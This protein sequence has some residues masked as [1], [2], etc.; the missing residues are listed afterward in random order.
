MAPKLSHHLIS[1]AFFL[2]PLL[3]QVSV[4]KSE[5]QFSKSLHF[6][7]GAQIGHA[8]KGLNQ[9]K[10]YFNA[11]GYYPSGINLTDDFDDL[12]ESALKIYQKQYRLEV[13]GK[14]D[15]DTIENML[16]PRCGV[17]DVF[18]K[19]NDLVEFDMV[20]NYTF[21]N[22]M[23]RWN[24]RQLTY[25]FRSSAQ[26]IS[27]QQLRPIIARAFQRWAAV[28]GFTFQE[29]PLFTQA[30][31][32]IGFHR[33]FHWDGY[34]FDGPGNVLAH[35]F[36]PQDGRLHY[37]ADENWSTTN[38]TTINQ[39]DLESVAVHEIGHILGL[40]HSQDPRAIMFA[41]YMPG[42]IKRNLGQDDI[43]GIRALYLG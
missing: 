25:T 23:P 24:T 3:V 20:A 17:Q 5:S 16:I 41:Y 32:V 10:Q 43:D 27:V 19:P 31:I 8:F 1:Y 18:N 26:V 39:I 28:S 11:F 15:S 2:L 38:L 4:V 21:F 22:G 36:A 35:A 34:P 37:D 9:V 40:G 7:Q 33:L 13:T 30:D 29:A 14:L 42:T 6:L 12:L